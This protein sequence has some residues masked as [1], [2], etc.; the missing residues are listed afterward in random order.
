MVAMSANGS[1]VAIAESAV[2]Q[3]QQQLIETGLL[4]ARRVDG[5]YTE[6]VLKVLREFRKAK[7]L[8]LTELPHPETLESLS[9]R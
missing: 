4:P 6:A 9:R 3:A 5:R 8:P 1:I 2:R 7:R